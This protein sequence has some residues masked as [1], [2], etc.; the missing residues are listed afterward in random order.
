MIWGRLCQ[1]LDFKIERY[2]RTIVNS[3]T[4]VKSSRHARGPFLRPPSSLVFSPL[5]PSEGSL[6]HTKGEESHFLCKV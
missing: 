1:I 5:R 2:S 4:R 6:N 3:V